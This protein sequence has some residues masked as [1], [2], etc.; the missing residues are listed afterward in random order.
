[1]HPTFFEIGPVTIKSYGVLVAT[2]FFVGFYLLHREAKRKNFYP[3]KI[4]DLELWILIFGIIGA[5]L[6]HVLVNIGYYRNAPLEILLVW[7]G[8]L[9]VYGGILFA[10]AALWI[11]IV[12]NKMPLLKT[13]DF[14]IPYVALGQS[15]GRIGCFLNGCCFGRP[16]TGS[17]PGVMFPGEGILRYP[18]QLY[19]SLALLAIFVFLNLAK[20]KNLR[21][22]F[23]FG[24]YLLLYS[25][26]RFSIDILRGDTPRYIFGLT[27]SQVISVVV[28]VGGCFL[29]KGLHG[30]RNV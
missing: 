25:A 29:I 5:R 1:M 16:V 4:L 12:R 27:I 2:A 11:S 14:I 30:K 19:S 23:V 13:A 3:D 20:G 10:I 21:T 24:F 26:Q 7:H 9:A 15:I 18:T 6:L 8:G 28:F 22:G 17:F